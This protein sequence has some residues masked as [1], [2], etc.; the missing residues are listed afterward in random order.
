MSVGRLV[1]VAKREEC[2]RAEIKEIDPWHSR[3]AITIGTASDL[4]MA[5]LPSRLH[6]SPSYQ[7][8]AAHAANTAR[9]L[10]LP[11]ETPAKPASITTIRLN[12]RHCKASNSTMA[13]LDT[14][15]TTGSVR[16]RRYGVADVSI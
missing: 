2:R 9:Q 10:R 3:G 5:A 7:H 16:N 8:A 4:D 1:V 13:E 12:P 11:L 6:T 14:D 15:R